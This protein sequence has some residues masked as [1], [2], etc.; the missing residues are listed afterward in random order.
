M[1]AKIGTMFQGQVQGLRMPK[2]EGNEVATAACHSTPRKSTHEAAVT[3][4]YARDCTIRL[5]AKGNGR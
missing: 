4:D 2:Q 1:R 5:L 3:K